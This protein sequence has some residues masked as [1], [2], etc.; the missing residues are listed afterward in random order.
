MDEQGATVKSVSASSGIKEDEIYDCL[1]TRAMPKEEMTRKLARA[2]GVGVHSLDPP[3][4]PPRHFSPSRSRGPGPRTSRLLAKSAVRM[5]IPAASA[6]AP[7]QESPL[8]RADRRQKALIQ[9]LAKKGIFTRD[10]WEAK[11]AEV[12]SRP[13]RGTG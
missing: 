5:P 6:Q 4:P 3:P 1:R 2:L 8:A 7:G 12:I 11:M 13:P 10:E 9:L